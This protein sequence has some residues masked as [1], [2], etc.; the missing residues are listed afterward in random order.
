M[1]RILSIIAVLSILSLGLAVGSRA[2]SMVQSGFTSYRTT[3]LVGL[4]VK[5]R[6]GVQLGQI[7]DLVVDSHGH[8]DFAI[9]NQPGF[10]QFSGALVVVPFGAL[11]I[12]KAK[13]GNI[14]LVF[15]E[16]KEKFYEGPEWYK[17]L[18]DM[19]Q[20]TSVDKYYGIQPYW[21]ESGKSSK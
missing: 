21:T 17:N 18:A 13:S 20:A 7:L 5:A 19:K 16:D 12:S 8:L 2:N 1:K 3:K 6:D 9:I 4:M 11:T 10:G 15:N 14:L